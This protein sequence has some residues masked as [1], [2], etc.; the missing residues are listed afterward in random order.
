MIWSEKSFNQSFVDP[1]PR[2]H[3]AFILL[4]RDELQLVVG[5][6]R[7]AVISF[8]RFCRISGR[9]VFNER[10]YQLIPSIL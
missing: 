1:V 2:I 3:I 7:N 4:S 8:C 6:Q 10:P 5:G 9:L